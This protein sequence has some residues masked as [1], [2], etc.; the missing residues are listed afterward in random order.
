MENSISSIVAELVMC[1]I[2]RYKLKIVQVYASATSYSN[3]YI[4][5]F[6]SDVDETS[7]K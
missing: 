1:I 2:K 5:N 6:Y 3:K 7:G 4:N